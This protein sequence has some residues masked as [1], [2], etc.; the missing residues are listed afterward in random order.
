MTP[1]SGML[2]AVGCG[3]FVIALGLLVIGILRVFRNAKTNQMP[4]IEDVE[5]GEK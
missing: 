3:L 1:I 2:A 4:G 5:T